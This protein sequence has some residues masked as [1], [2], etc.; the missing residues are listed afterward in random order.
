MLFNIYAHITTNS[1]YFY[2]SY[3]YFFFLFFFI[4]IISKYTISIVS[5]ISIIIELSA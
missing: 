1:Y 3:Y 2:Y 5:I 4:I